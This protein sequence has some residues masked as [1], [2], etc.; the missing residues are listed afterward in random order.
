M[1]SCSIKKSSGP[2]PD[3]NTDT[4]KTCHALHGAFRW[5]MTRHV[6]GPAAHAVVV[7]H[8]VNPE[9]TTFSISFGC[10]RG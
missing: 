6:A 8:P 3:R 5:D 10:I 7:S 4:V 2:V 9:A 1:K